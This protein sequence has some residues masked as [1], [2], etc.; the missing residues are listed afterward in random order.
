MTD[1][2]FCPRH[3]YDDSHGLPSIE[4]EFGI[5]P[6]PAEFT[7]TYIEEEFGIFQVSEQIYRP[8]T[9]IFVSPRVYM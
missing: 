4:E 1:F 3:I 8:E 6:N 7:S 2:P 9:G 5:F